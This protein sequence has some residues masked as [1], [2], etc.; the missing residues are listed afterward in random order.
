MLTDTKFYEI[1]RGDLLC[2]VLF[3][4]VKSKVK[5][6]NE[7]GWLSMMQEKYDGWNPKVPKF[8]YSGHSAEK[9]KREEFRKKKTGKDHFGFPEYL[10]IDCMLPI[11]D[12]EGNITKV[13]DNQIWAPVL[14]KKYAHWYDL[15]E[16]LGR[17]RSKWLGRSADGT[18]RMGWYGQDEAKDNCMYLYPVKLYAESMNR[19]YNKYK[20]PDVQGLFYKTRSGASDNV[21]VG[22]DN[23]TL[24]FETDTWGETEAERHHQVGRRILAIHKVVKPEHDLNRETI[25]KGKKFVCSETFTEDISDKKLQHD[26]AIKMIDAYGLDITRIRKKYGQV[27]LTPEIVR[28]EIEELKNGP[29]QIPKAWR[30]GNKYP[31]FYTEEN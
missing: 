17:W 11:M 28:K 26:N 30:I 10:K 7:K 14:N 29:E 8:L 23:N 9:K 5:T 21:G 4:G 19:I 13:S 31:E 15:M 2:S 12:I 18:K 6:L 20:V 1:T 24:K 22:G 25:D 27:H 16:F 3:L